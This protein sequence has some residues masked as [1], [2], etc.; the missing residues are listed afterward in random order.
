MIK[1]LT[2]KKWISA[3]VI[4]L[5]CAALGGVLLWIYGPSALMGLRGLVPQMARTQ[6]MENI[7]IPAALGLFFMALAVLIFIRQLSLSVGKQVKRYLA[8]HPEVTLE[9]IDND[10]A[11]AGQF[12]NVWIGDRWTYSYDMKGILV[13]NENLVRVFS[14]AHGGRRVQ[15]YLCLELTDGNIVRIGVAQRHLSRIREQYAEYS[16]GRKGNEGEAGGSN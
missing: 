7:Y 6:S 5:F 4:I 14:E 8:G 16:S 3:G 10:F 2:I 13:E 12:G 11:A 15:Y 1:K 9:Q